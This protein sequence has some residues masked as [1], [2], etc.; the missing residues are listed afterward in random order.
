MF[1]EEGSD[2]VCRRSGRSST[3]GLT[4]APSARGLL[5]GRLDEKSSQQ[6][7]RA[8]SRGGDD[9][10]MVRS[11]GEGCVVNVPFDCRLSWACRDGT[12]I[13][14]QADKYRICYI[15]N[16]CPFP[17]CSCCRSL[18]GDCKIR[19]HS[20]QPPNTYRW[21]CCSAYTVFQLPLSGMPHRGGV[22]AFGC[23]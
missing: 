11:Q 6:K 12:Y 8:N 9:D 7:D 5:S 2:V 23:G 4:A 20:H 10:E 19:S 15:S 22:E 21:T 3:F 16:R 13:L 17:C 14:S 18:L 1:G